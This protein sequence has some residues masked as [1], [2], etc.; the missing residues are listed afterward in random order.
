MKVNKATGLVPVKVK[1]SDASAGIMSGEI[2]GF[3]PAVAEQLVA[4]GMAEPVESD[5]KEQKA[6]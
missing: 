2:R 6:A 1:F 3:L 5:A 4:K